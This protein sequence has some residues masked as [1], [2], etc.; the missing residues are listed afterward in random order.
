MLLSVP[1]GDWDALTPD[2]QASISQ[3]SS[4]HLGTPVVMVNDT[5]Q[6]WTCWDD[7]R[8]TEQDIATLAILFDDP[9]L[10]PLPEDDE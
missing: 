6:T 7:H 5:S 2:Q 3:Q 10:I 9:S 1:Q 4:I 8:F